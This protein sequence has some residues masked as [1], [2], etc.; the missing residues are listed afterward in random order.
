MNWQTPP[1][2]INNYSI[3]LT[4][5][6]AQNKTCLCLHNTMVFLPIEYGMANKTS[7]TTIDFIG[8]PTG[9][10]YPPIDFHFFFLSV[11][12]ICAFYFR[13]CWSGIRHSID[14]FPPSCLSV[15]IKTAIGFHCFQDWFLSFFRLISFALSIRFCL[16]RSTA[17]ARC[18]QVGPLLRLGGSFLW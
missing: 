13:W 18:R 16:L 8:H 5:L 12:S 11:P 10:P 15:S 7:P 6:T 2:K 3:F 9:W 4:T 17:S 1:A 14:W